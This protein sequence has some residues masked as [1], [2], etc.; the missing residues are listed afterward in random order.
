MELL[1]SFG[2]EEYYPAGTTI[3]NEGDKGDSLYIILDGNVR[4][5]KEISGIGEEALAILQKGDYFGEMALIDDDKRSADAKAHSRGV[6]L[7]SLTKKSF[8]D[9]ISSDID[10]AAKFIHIIC[11]ILSDR[12]YDLHDKVCQWKIIAGSF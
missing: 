3:F 8:N 12:L 7:L 2:R 5:S 11:R 9:I 4:I 10:V 6:T 1:T